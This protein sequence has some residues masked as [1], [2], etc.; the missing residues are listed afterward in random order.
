MG[1]TPNHHELPQSEHLRDDINLPAGPGDES[2]A[3]F[4]EDSFTSMELNAGQHVPGMS[5]LGE[6]RRGDN[7]EHRDFSD[8]SVPDGSDAEES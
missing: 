2:A 5:P 3:E 6:Y 4:S 7:P 1:W 8:G